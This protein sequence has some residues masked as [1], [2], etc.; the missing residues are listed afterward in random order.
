MNHL[1]PLERTPIADFIYYAALSLWLV[2]M[3]FFASLF[4]GYIDGNVFRAI[5]VVSLILALVSCMMTIKLSKKTAISILLAAI[6]IISVFIADQGFVLDLVVFMF[7]AQD[8]DFRT[9]AKVALVTLSVSV[10]FIIVSSFLGLIENYRSLSGSRERYYLGFR[11][12]LRAPQFFMAIAALWIYLKKKDF[13]AFGVV[14]LLI[15]DCAIYAFSGSR[16]SFFL[17]A[18]LI[19]LAGY[20]SG[21]KSMF[22]K[23]LSRLLSFAYPAMAIFSL[24][25]VLAYSPT[26][27]F[28]RALDAS[29]VLGGRLSLGSQAID[30]YGISFFG[31]QIT[32]VGNGLNA[33]GSIQNVGEYNYIDNL[34]IKLLVQLGVV[35]TIIYLAIFTYAGIKAYKNN[36]CFTVLILAMLAFS[37]LINDL[38]LYL[39]FNPFALLVAIAAFGKDQPF[40]I[41]THKKR[42]EW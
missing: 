7:C 11:H 1:S 26:N 10:L 41:A 34:Y 30:K 32:V 27:D 16:T 21:A 38:T 37:G 12:A 18:V 5:R 31:Q 19:V 8:R 36:D 24:A 15:I 35:F 13:S 14:L 6:A 39:E 22:P 20:F 40:A 3:V 17:T 4:A 25:I 33:D 23:R 29:S 28:L 2:G 9:V 42:M